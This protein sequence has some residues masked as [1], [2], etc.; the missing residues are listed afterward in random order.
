MRLQISEIV[1]AVNGVLCGD[2]QIDGINTSE[3]IIENISTDTRKL[4][5]NSLFIA[6][7][8]ESFDAHDF[9]NQV[10]SSNEAKIVL[11]DKNESALSLI[12]I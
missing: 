6:L 10:V 7:K 2:S 8:G 4:L 11:I 5:Q 9:L 3:F 1:K 12:H